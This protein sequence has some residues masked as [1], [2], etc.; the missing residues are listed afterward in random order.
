[1]GTDDVEG[2]GLEQTSL[3]CTFCLPN[4]GPRGTSLLCFHTVCVDMR[5]NKPI[6]VVDDW[7]ITNFAHGLVG[8]D[9]K[10]L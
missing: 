5:V 3:A 1:M 7:C 4:R 9:P 2:Y 10:H 6:V 8:L